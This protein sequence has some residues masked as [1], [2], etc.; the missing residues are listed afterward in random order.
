LGGE[1][2]ENQQKQIGH[3]HGGNILIDKYEDESCSTVDVKIVGTG[4]RGPIH[5]LFHNE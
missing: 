3:L 4:L 5:I 2:H 1:D